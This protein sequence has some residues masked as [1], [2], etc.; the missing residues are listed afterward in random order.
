MNLIRANLGH[1]Q[2]GIQ[3]QFGMCLQQHGIHP[4]NTDNVWRHYTQQWSDAEKRLKQNEH[5]QFDP[6]GELVLLVNPVDLTELV[7]VLEK[8]V[9]VSL[10]ADLIIKIENRTVYDNSLQHS[11][12]YQCTVVFSM[13][14][15]SHV[16]VMKKNPVSFD[17]AIHKPLDFSELGG[18]ESGLLDSRGNFPNMDVGAVSTL[19]NSP[20]TNPSPVPS[21]ITPQV[22]AP[23]GV[24]PPHLEASSLET[25]EPERKIAREIQQGI[26]ATTH[27]DFGTTP[28]T[29]Q[30]VGQIEKLHSISVEQGKKQKEARAK[31]RAGKGG[32]KKSSASLLAEKYQKDTHGFGVSGSTDQVALP[33]MA[34][35]IPLTPEDNEMVMQARTNLA[36]TCGMLEKLTTTT[37]DFANNLNS[38][39]IFFGDESAAL[40]RCTHC[41]VHCLNLG[42]PAFQ[43]LAKNSVR[44]A[45]KRLGSQKSR[46]IGGPKKGR[47]SKLRSVHALKPDD[48]DEEDDSEDEEEDDKMDSN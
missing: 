27:V 45:R 37:L 29:Q 47:P 2:K 16:Q 44:K 30:H 11:N 17:A 41:P 4:V 36:I 26:Q 34:S 31:I 35:F 48:P 24:P 39:Y 18:L 23:P 13:D 15:L 19:L 8:P 21:M 14:S 43:R 28:V 20:L 25:Q 40:L 1:L 7:R 46:A 42:S 3:K 10:K 33:K 38:G 12:E 32:T 6:F 9:S 22:F 5:V